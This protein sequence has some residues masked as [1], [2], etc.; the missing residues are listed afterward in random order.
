M[1]LNWTIQ[2]VI[3]LCTA[4]IPERGL[5]FANV[6]HNLSPSILHG[7]TQA[8]K[9]GRAMAAWGAGEVEAPPTLQSSAQVALPLS[10]K[11]FMSSLSFGWVTGL[12][13][14]GNK[15]VLQ[16]SD[17][18]RLEEPSLMANAS[19]SWNGL[20]NREKQREQERVAS[21]LKNTNAT[22]LPPAKNLLE[23][24]WRSPITKATVKL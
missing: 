22:S 15:N 7:T 23:E 20:F 18:W 21:V 6:V 16:S 5:C 13:D 24:F 9:S 3:A 2:L 19:E 4:L 14:R 12:M 11:N 1:K 8:K 10:K 17:L